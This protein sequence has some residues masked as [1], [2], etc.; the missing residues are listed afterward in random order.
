MTTPPDDL[1][2]RRRNQTRAEIAAA[3]VE[4]FSSVGFDATTM[5]EVAAAAGVSRRTAYRHF[6]SKD[7]LIFEQ[8]RLW[9]EQFTAVIEDRADGESARDLLRRAVLAVADHIEAHSDAV[10][11]SFTILMSTDSLL[12]RHGKSDAEWR[13]LCAVV[14]ADDGDGSP[15]A[16]LQTMVAT[17]A[18]I[19]ATNAMIAAW[20]AGQPDAHLPTVA[21]L[22]FDQIDSIWPDFAR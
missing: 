4:L 20:A 16:Q 2:T 17:G 19:G 15:E 21:A 11:R 18:L 10:L 14:I 8:P 5:D 13:E 6:A 9:L 12:G 3:A 7:E 1:A 22:A